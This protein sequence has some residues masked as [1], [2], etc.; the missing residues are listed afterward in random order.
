MAVLVDEKPY[1]KVLARYEREGLVK[2]LPA[3]SDH[4]EADI[5]VLPHNDVD[6]TYYEQAPG[7]AASV[8]PSRSMVLRSDRVRIVTI[9]L[10]ERQK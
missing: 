1:R 5:L 3:W 2:G 8:S 9:G 6:P 10:P 7:F 4:G